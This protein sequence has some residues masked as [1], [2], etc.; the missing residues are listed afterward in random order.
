[1]K[2]LAVPNDVRGSGGKIW[3]EQQALG[4]A[5]LTCPT[6]YQTFTLR[7][8]N[9]MFGQQGKKFEAPFTKRLA[10]SF[11]AK[12]LA[13]DYA[14]N[15]EKARVTINDWVEAQTENKI[16]DLLAKGMIKESTKLTLVNALYL[17][18]GWEQPFAPEKTRSRVFYLGPKSQ[19]QVPMMER[20]GALQDYRY[21]KVGDV[22]LVEL[23]LGDGSIMMTLYVPTLV[24][25]L[26]ALEK[27]LN[28]KLVA[29]YEAALAARKV[30]LTLPKFN[31][32]GSFQLA[33]VLKKLGAGL[34]FDPKKAD[35]KGIDGGKD[36]LYISDVV[37]KTF[38]DV[39]EAG[40]EAAA[41]TATTMK[42][43]AAP[44]PPQE[45]VTVV[46]DRPFFFVVRLRA[47]GVPLLMGRIVDP[48]ASAG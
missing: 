36:G 38:I 42:S 14:K 13:V 46:V 10:G 2:T 11:D 12:P 39:H 6:E 21:A 22:E 7:M 33:R 9:A 17:K 1:M 37:H 27:S 45:P 5:R 34:A 30:N 28:P 15:P 48:R 29:E 35:F 24:D 25:G 16:R 20:E 8:A 41:A 47:D 23:G 3:F 44:P 43:G 40:M 31:A 19:I 26:A 4:L 32:T 18:A